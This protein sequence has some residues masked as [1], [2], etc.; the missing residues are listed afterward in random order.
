MAKRKILV[1]DDEKDVRG[2]VKAMLGAKGYE[3]LTALTGKE[4]LEK[5]VSE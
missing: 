2:L 3:A 5:T 4:G 1:V